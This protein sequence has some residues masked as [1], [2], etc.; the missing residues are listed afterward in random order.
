MTVPNVLF[1]FKLSEKM[2]QNFIPTVAKT[3]Q[4]TTPLIEHETPN[5]TGEDSRIPM[6]ALFMNLIQKRRF[7]VSLRN[8]E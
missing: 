8:N 1:S 6:G 5:L 4:A 2:T 3:C 7:S